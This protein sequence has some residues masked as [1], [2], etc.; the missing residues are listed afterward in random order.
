MKFKVISEAA[1]KKNII[2]DVIFMIIWLERNLRTLSIKLTE[3]IFFSSSQ[4]R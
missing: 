3:M 2:S 1:L 4:M